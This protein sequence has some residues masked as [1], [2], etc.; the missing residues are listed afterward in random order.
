MTIAEAIERIQFA[1]PQIYYACH[2]R[3]ARRR[4]TAHHVSGRDSEILVHLDRAAPTSLSALARHMDLSLSTLSEA[5]TKLT[6]HGYVVK[7]PGRAG[8]RRQV[9]ERLLRR[10]LCEI[11]FVHTHPVLA[12]QRL[13][14]AA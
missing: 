2:T 12:P 4:S 10:F 1:Y 3:H 14:K 7:T 8:D 9:V 11:G 5:I 13:H 6:A